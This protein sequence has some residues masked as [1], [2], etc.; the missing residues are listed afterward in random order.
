M[1]LKYP[2]GPAGACTST[3]STSYWGAFQD[4]DCPAVTSLSSPLLIFFYVRT[5]HALRTY[6]LR[7][8]SPRIA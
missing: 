2:S 7:C 8:Y 6:L 3:N 1:N 5:A 4:P